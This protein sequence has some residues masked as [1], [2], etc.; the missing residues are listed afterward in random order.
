[1]GTP[2]FDSAIYVNPQNYKVSEAEFLEPILKWVPVIFSITAA[3]LALILYGLFSEK[4]YAFVNSRLGGR[5][6]T[7]LNNK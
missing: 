1:M 5:M 7:F 4:T 3:T 6:Y 2:F